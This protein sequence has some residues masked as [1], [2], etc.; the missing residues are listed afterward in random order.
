MKLL[1][2]TWHKPDYLA[3]QILIGLR[4]LLGADCVDWP[5]KDAVYETC[6][7]DLSRYHAGGFT[8]WKILGDIEIDRGGVYEKDWDLVV[9]SKV[10]SRRVRREFGR[11]RCV[12]SRSCRVCFLDGEDHPNLFEE[13]L[14]SGPYF[15]R[16]LAVPDARVKP[17]S[18]SIPE[19]WI[20]RTSMVKTKLFPRHVQ[21]KEAYKLT[22]VSAGSVREHCFTNQ[23]EYHDDLGRSLFGVTMKKSGWDCMRHYEIAA[24]H[25][26]PCF[27]RLGDKPATCAP[28]GLRD[29]HNVIGFDDAEELWRKQALVEELGLYDS[30]Q[31]N[32]VAWVKDHTC[33]QAAGRIV[34]CVT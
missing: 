7:E 6:Q 25:T 20:R 5:K 31:R 11:V 2:L 26:V 3:D 23:T 28:H 32:V 18:F 30:L 24:N 21:C 22:A 9:V 4:R 27:Y 10:F 12:R 19:K 33:Q 1:Y 14:G 13:V 16:E 34:E 29:M 15:K 8:C 17:I